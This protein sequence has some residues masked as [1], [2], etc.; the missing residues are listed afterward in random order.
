MMIEI[1]RVNYDLDPTSLTPLVVPK[2]LQLVD[3]RMSFPRVS[4]LHTQHYPQKGLTVSGRG[5]FSVHDLPFLPSL[6]G[7]TAI[8]RR[9]ESRTR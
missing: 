6:V 3:T 1:R 5:S 4:G 7:Y 2:G 8:S 9:L